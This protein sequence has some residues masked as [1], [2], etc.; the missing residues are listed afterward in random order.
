MSKLIERFLNYVKYD[1]KSDENSSTLPSTEGQV[2]FG[3]SLVEELKAIGMSEVSMDDKGFV[4][5]TL[6]SM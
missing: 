2:V 4:M 5:A 1:T 3:K 6:P